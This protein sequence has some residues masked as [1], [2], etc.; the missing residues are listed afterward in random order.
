MLD[1]RAF[2]EKSALLSAL[3]FL[4]RAISAEEYERDVAR[5]SAPTGFRGQPCV[6]SSANGINGVKLAYDRIA[7]G[8]DTLDAIIAG[9]NLV[10]LDPNN[11]SVGLGGLPNEDGV[12]QL[13]ASCMHGPSRRAGAVGCLE[14]IATPSLVAK[15]VMDYTDH[16]MLVGEGAK[17][18]ALAVGFKPQ[19]LLTEQ[20]RKDWLRWKARLSDRDHWFEPESLEALKFTHGTINMNAVNAGGDLSSVT[21]TSGDSYKLP[22]RLGDSPIH[23]AG[24]YTDNSVGSA[25]STGQG[26]L[27]IKTCGA[28]LAVELLRRGVAPEQAALTVLERALAVSEK[29]RLD[30]RGRPRYDLQFYVLTKDGRC[31]GA[32]MYEGASFAVCDERGPRL[33]KCAYLFKASE[34]PR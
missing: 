1:R 25:G 4:P 5:T 34:H 9:V 17:R 23:G 2:L 21:T 10:E 18:F 14:D 20:S 16:V 11:Q 28:F 24:Q 3:G 12:V 13:D 22:G 7:G 31:A 19:N 26:E 6:V 8:A 27:N 33:E 30:E 15:A 32:T 29:R